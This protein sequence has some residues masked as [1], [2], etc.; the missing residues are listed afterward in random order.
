MPIM[1]ARRRVVV[2]DLESHRNADAWPTNRWAIDAF[3]APL[4]AIECSGVVADA[5]GGGGEEAVGTDGPA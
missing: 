2:A 4:F 3:L 5:H 1:S